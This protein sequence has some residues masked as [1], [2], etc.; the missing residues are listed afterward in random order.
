MVISVLYVDDEKVLR[1]TLKLF[2]EKNPDIRVTSIPSATEALELLKKTNFDAII[3]DYEM[4]VMDG[5]EFLKIVRAQYPRLPF[6]I[7]TG[8]GR[9][10]IVIESINNGADFYVKKGGDPKAQ[11]AELTNMVRSSVERREQDKKIV[12]LN[13][14]YL[15]LSRIN[16]AVVRIHDQNEL[17]REVCKIAVGEGNFIRAWIGCA[18]ESTRQIH[19]IVASGTID[20]FFTDI[21]ESTDALPDDKSLTGTAIWDGLFTICNNIEQDPMMAGWVD[22]ARHHGYRSAASFPLTNGTTVRCALTFFSREPDFFTDSEIQLLRE[23]TENVSFALETIELEINKTKIREELEHSEHLL[24]TLINFFPEPVFAIDKSGSVIIWNKAMEGF[25]DVSAEEVLGKGDYEYSAR[26]IGKRKP[27]L[28]D[29]VF[30]T[31]KELKEKKYSEITRGRH[32]IRAETK[33]TDINGRTRTLF[34]TASPLLDERGQYIGAIESVRD[35]SQSKHAIELS[36][37]V[38]YSEDAGIWMVD[39]DF[40]T[41]F[42]NRK[43]AEML[44]EKP[45][46]VIGRRFQEFLF[47]E[48]IKNIEAMF[49]QPCRGERGCRY[50]SFEQNLRNASGKPL[51]FRISATGLA[52]Q[53]EPFSGFFGLFRYNP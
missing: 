3:S 39:K 36:G 47:E 16:E 49:M 11:F 12:R 53:N 32:I 37:A 35:I 42:V 50:G 24:T 2:L 21:Q 19:A 27:V 38:S 48:D 22:D 7:F 41:L 18:D 14:L 40:V 52:R 34:V 31:D 44:G 51:L 26:I 23:L 6:I 1:D 43:M 9:E 4:P 30:A 17:M 28:I 29:M 46:T 25:S 15:V 5:I 8:K 10:E 45:E 20:G 33:V 13:R